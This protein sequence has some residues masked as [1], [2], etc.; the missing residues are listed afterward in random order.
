MSSQWEAS[1]LAQAL[2]C[3][4]LSALVPAKT[5]VRQNL[6]SGRG[7][8]RDQQRPLVATLP[9]PTA[10]DAQLLPRKKD[11]VTK[12][13]REGEDVLPHATH[14]GANTILLIQENICSALIQ[15]GRQTR[16]P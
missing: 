1:L 5:F 4:Y 11:L 13:G 9:P 2:F 8:H 15:R 6:P 3:W 7:D 14:L 12:G 16:C 10:S